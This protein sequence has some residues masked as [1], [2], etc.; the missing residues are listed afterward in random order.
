MENS[1]DTNR[2]K[3]VTLQWKPL[4]GF[5]LCIVLTAIAF[6]AALYADYSPKIIFLMIAVFAFI[7]AVLQ[8]FQIELLE[9]DK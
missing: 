8:L 2:Q 1:R 3:T 4:V 6:W 9:N 7:Q 5:T